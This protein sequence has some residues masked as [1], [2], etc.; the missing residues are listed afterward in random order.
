MCP[1]RCL[2]RQRHIHGHMYT[3]RPLPA[4]LTWRGART[5]EEGVDNAEAEDRDEEDEEEEISLL[6]F[7]SCV[8]VR[9]R[10]CACPCAWEGQK[11]LQSAPLASLLFSTLPAL[12]FLHGGEAM[13]RCVRQLWRRAVGRAGNGRELDCA[14]VGAARHAGVLPHWVG[15]HHSA[16]RMCRLQSVD[17]SYRCPVS[18]PFSPYALSLCVCA[19]QRPSA[20]RA[21]QGRCALTAGG[22]QVLR[23]GSQVSARQACFQCAHQHVSRTHRQRRHRHPQSV[24]A[25]L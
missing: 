23:G 16:S 13:T 19:C 12:P 24:S 6:V 1:Y 2:Y 17:R 11:D 25:P 10:A 15:A 21:G 7:R 5:E 22:W 3:L 18:I 4:V 9:V 14:R 20:V 8:R